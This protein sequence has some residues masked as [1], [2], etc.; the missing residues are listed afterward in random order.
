MFRD[1]SFRFRQDGSRTFLISSG[2]AIDGRSQLTANQLISIDAAQDLLNQIYHLWLSKIGAVEIIGL[3][4]KERPAIDTPDVVSNLITFIEPASSMP[5]LTKMLQSGGE[6]QRLIAAR[7][8]RDRAPM[9]SQRP[10]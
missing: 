3:R 10:L 6:P 9:E 1:A 7:A 5:P 8:D 2:C 4:G